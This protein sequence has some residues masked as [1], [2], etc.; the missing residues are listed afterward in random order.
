MSDRPTLRA[1]LGRRDLAL[2]PIGEIADDDLDR[3][4]RWIHSS[5]LADPTPFLDEGVALLTTGTQFAAMAD[6]APYVERLVRRGVAALGFGTEV[7]RDGVPDDLV[8]ACAAAGLPLFEVPFRTPFIAVA[9]ANADALAAEAYARRSWALAAQRAISLAALR[10][11]ALGAALAELASQLGR[12]VGLYDATGALTHAR[13]T[14]LP[15]AAAQGLRD[16]VARLLAAEVRA[17]ETIAIEGSAFQIQTLGRGGALRGALVVEAAADG[18]LDQEE[19]G[20]VTTV[21]AMAGF[22]L[23]QREE[24]TL[25]RAALRAGVLR[26]LLRGELDLARDVAEPWGGLPAEPVTVGLLRDASDAAL[27]YLELRAAQLRGRIAFGE[28]PAGGIAII[29]GRGAPDVFGEVARRFDTGIGV[30]LSGPYA[31]LPRAIDQARAARGPEGVR[32]FGEAD[33]AVLDA[34]GDDARAA[35]R[36]VL[37]PL[38][39]HPELTAT[40]R[41]WLAHDARYD[42]A[43]RALGVHRHTVRAR[44]AR[45]AELLGRDL[46]SFAARAELWAALRATGLVA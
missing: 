30:S 20:V 32:V 8:A 40:L 12:W 36:A 4:L 23:E 45:A 18:R 28:L 41:A 6:H 37:A 13:P 15:Q 44:V 25:A 21:V 24:L 14:R 2:R 5:D 27:S 34:L 33:V 26:A 38:D 3:T 16:E 35:A 9:R 29:A 7:V 43:A 46:A 22:A 31:R 19:R 17:A 42:D 39:G 10:P 1:L 11:D